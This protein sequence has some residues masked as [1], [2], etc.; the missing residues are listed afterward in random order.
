M[1]L[2]MRILPA[3]AVAAAVLAV[4]LISPPAQAEPAASGAETE[5]PFDVLVYSRTT[6]FRHSSIEVGV[7]ALE[8][9]G[10]E[11]GFGVDAT[12]D[13]AAFT[14]ENL[15]RYAAVIFL[16]TTGDVLEGEQQRDLRKY[17]R[18]GGGYMGIHSAADTE[19]EWPF[20]GRLVGAYFESHPLQQIA[21]FD[22]EGGGHP[23]TAHLG[24]R[25]TTLDEFYSFKTNPRPDVRVLLTIDEGTYSPDPN[26]T[27]LPGNT[28]SSGVMGDHPM[29]WCHSNVGGR[30]F[31]TAL[32]H[33]AYLYEL[34]WYRRHLLGGILTATRQVR[35]NCSVSGR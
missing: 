29:S 16:N 21:A 33:E 2:P 4:A 19:H 34:D 13:P 10:A 35:V 9:I 15:E 7:A 20:Y 17:V 31:Y 8:S 12:E 24:E 27:N 22:N 30:V 14:L 32:G 3:I 26:T 6:T 28:P 1:S 25:F 23:A 18:Q 11:H 5:Q